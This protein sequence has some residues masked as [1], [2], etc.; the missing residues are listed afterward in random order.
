MVAEELTKEKQNNNETKYNEYVEKI[1]F[2]AKHLKIKVKKLNDDDSKQVYL[3]TPLERLEV[4]FSYHDLNLKYS[5]NIDRYVEMI[6]TIL[7]KE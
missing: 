7:K 5:Y 2:I 3:Y 4:I 6:K 1:N